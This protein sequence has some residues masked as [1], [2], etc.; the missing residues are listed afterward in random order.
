M[1]VTSN[2][3]PS[4]PGNGRRLNTAKLTEIN[5]QT[6]KNLAKPKFCKTPVVSKATAIIPPVSFHALGLVNKSPIALTNK[7]EDSPK[8]RKLL[9][10]AWP[11]LSW[12]VLKY[13]EQP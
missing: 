3:Q 7:T 13:K 4:K 8:S 10:N 9:P 2:C 1:K 5:A 12:T 11:A 6:Y